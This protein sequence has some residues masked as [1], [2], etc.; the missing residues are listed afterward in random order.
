MKRRVTVDI[1]E[2]DE[3]ISEWA[4]EYTDTYRDGVWGVD[5]VGV[6]HMY[7]HSRNDLITFY[8]PMEL[9]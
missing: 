4:N 2:A 6:Y 7:H 1:T 3:T 9:P 5:E 8:D